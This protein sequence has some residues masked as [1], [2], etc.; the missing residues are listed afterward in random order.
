MSGNGISTIGKCKFTLLQNGMVS[1]IKIG[2]FHLSVWLIGKGG[3]Q[4][5]RRPGFDSWQFA[6]Q[7]EM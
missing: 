1:Y 2:F 5:R 7:A 4:S 6:T 3:W